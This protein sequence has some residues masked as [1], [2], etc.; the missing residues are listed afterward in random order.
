MTAVATAVV[1][2]ATPSAIGELVNVLAK[3]VARV[4]VG[5]VAQAGAATGASGSGGGDGLLGRFFADPAINAAALKLLGLFALN[6]EGQRVHA[7]PAFSCT[8]R[9]QQRGLDA[10]GGAG[11][12]ALTT[13]YVS[14]MSVV[15]EN[16]AERLRYAL[17]HPRRTPVPKRSDCLCG[18]IRSFAGAS[19][20]SRSCTRTCSSLTRTSRASC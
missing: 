16:L 19:C 6:G 17:P 8:G 3:A 1:N 5:G 12:G 18:A 20:S 4:P 7:D 11:T 14:T 2:L 9:S 10:G 13:L 15:G